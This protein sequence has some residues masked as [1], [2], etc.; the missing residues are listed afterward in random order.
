ARAVLRLKQAAPGDFV[1][2]LRY[3][4]TGG[5][6]WLSTGISFDV[7]GDN[8]VLVYLS[9]YKGGPKVQVSYK[10]GGAYVYPPGGMVPLPG[11]RNEEQALVVRGG[12]QLLN[13]EVKG[14]HVLAYRLPIPRKAGA[15]ELITYDA[16]ASLAE[17][18]LLALPATVMMVPAGSKASA[19]R[20]L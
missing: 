13:V 19:P 9:A 7:A 8:E 6:M 5:K 18:E 2:R 4:P 16:R 20:V 17:F 10:R 1:A 3:T 15:M 12:G 14:R 11:K